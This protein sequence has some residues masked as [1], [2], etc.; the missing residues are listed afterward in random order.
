MLK[1]FDQCHARH[2]LLP[3]LF[4]FLVCSP[5]A[6]PPSAQQQ[7]DGFPS[8]GRLEYSVVRNNENIGTE[9]V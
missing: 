3:V 1:P 8:V 4:V 9:I 6:E 7:T 5:L 2:A